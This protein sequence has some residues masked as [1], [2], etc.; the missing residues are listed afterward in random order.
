MTHHLL[1]PEETAAGW[2]LLFDGRSLNGWRTYQNKPTD[3]WVVEEGV[4]YCKGSD[5]DKSDLR[6]DLITAE[7]Y[8]NF[9]LSLEWKLAPSGNSGIMYLVS[10]AEAAA[11]ETGP[12]YQLLDDA[13][14]AAELEDWQQSGA[15]YAM[16]AP[17]VLA[18]NPVGEWNHTRIRVENGKVEHWLNGQQVVTYELWSEE[19]ERNKAAGKWKDTPSYGSARKGHI[20]LQDH[21]SEAWFRNIKIQLL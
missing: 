6:A 11:Y 15:N 17:S 12:E 3:S 20:A 9:D 14:Y 2:T 18:T 13:W 21:G 19:W 10:E 8:D 7:Q 1:T 5:T 4:L 16:N